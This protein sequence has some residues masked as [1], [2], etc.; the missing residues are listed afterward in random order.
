MSVVL[1]RGISIVLSRG[2]WMVKG[3]GHR[4]SWML[5]LL[6]STNNK[7]C[8]LCKLNASC[9]VYKGFYFSWFGFTFS[10]MHHMTRMFFGLLY[11]CNIIHIFLFMRGWNAILHHKATSHFIC[12]QWHPWF[13]FIYVY[14]NDTIHSLKKWKGGRNFMYY[15]P[16]E[17]MHDRGARR[18]LQKS[19]L[20]WCRGC[21]HMWHFT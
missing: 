18:A 15:C 19:L 8:P 11:P 9:L 10:A 1:S 20:H 12:D 16:W 21:G 13:L 14:C 4:N 7:I 6:T 5:N 17:P 3:L 2:I